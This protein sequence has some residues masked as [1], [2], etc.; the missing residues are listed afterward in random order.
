MKKLNKV[1]FVKPVFHIDKF[2]KV[3]D[4]LLQSNDDEMVQLGRAMRTTFESQ[5]MEMEEE[6]QSKHCNCADC[7]EDF[8]CYEEH[9]CAPDIESNYN[10][11]SCKSGVCD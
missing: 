9:K 7:G 6:P 5:M 11:N 2:F 3:A 8:L 10:A 1:E 4:H